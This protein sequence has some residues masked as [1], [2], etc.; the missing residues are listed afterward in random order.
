VEKALQ[1]TQLLNVFSQE[2]LIPLLRL[3]KGLH[4]RRPLPEFDLFCGP[5]TEILG[6][7]FHPH[8]SSIPQ[9]RWV[10]GHFFGFDWGLFALKNQFVFGL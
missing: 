3:V 4:N 9:K 2:F 8:P 10:F 1:R 6:I 5:H 7:D